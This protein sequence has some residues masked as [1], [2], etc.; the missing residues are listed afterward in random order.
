MTETNTSDTASTSDTQEM[1]TADLAFGDG[2]SG[3]SSNIQQETVSKS[4]AA[5]D[6]SDAPL[7][8]ASDA[9][10]FRARW[11]EVQA[12]FVDDPQAAVK[13]ADGLVAETMKRLAQMF[14]EE[15]EQLESQWS[16][17]GDVDTEALRVALQRYRSF[18]DRL[19]SV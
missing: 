6:S 4:S 15:R 5:S 11:H 16:S 1:S 13:Q 18:F 7:F 17:G 2:T 12:A 3:T 9:D 14:A 10:G 19:L 8:E